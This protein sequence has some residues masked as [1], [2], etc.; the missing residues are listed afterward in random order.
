MEFYWLGIGRKTVSELIKDEA[1]SFAFYIFSFRYFGAAFGNDSQCLCSTKS[2]SVAEH[3]FAFISGFDDFKCIVLPYLDYLME[4]KS[5]F[6]SR[7]F[8]IFN[9]SYFKMD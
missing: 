7:I 4:K 5:R 6:L 2:F 3:A 1:I 9:C 8:F